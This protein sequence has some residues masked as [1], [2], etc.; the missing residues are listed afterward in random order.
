MKLKRIIKEYF[1]YSASEQNGMIILLVLLFV[2][3][4][5]PRLFESKEADKACFDQEEQIHLDSLV[6]AIENESVSRSRDSLFFFDPNVANKSAFIKLG[7][8]KFQINNILKYRKK[9]G[10]FYR[11][12]D[13]RKIYG[14]R[15]TDYSRVCSYVKIETK[16]S[17][18]NVVA[19]KSKP[20]CKYYSFDPNTISVQTWLSFGVSRKISTRIQKYLKSGGRFRKASDLGKIYG[21]DSLKLKD[22]MPFVS[23]K[24][25]SPVNDKSVNIS[26]LDLNLADTIQLRGMPGIG[27]VLS[28]RIVKYRNLLG[29]FVDKRQLLEV[30]GMSNNEYERI[31]NS[32]SIHTHNISMIDLNSIRLGKLKK[33]PYVSSR[34]ASDIIRY[35]DRNGIFKNKKE[36][37]SKRILSDSVY[38]KIVPYLSLK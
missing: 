38:K 30:Y 8:D 21:M 37:L 29:G 6:Q 4:I 25:E 35:R 20:S 10:W 15:K 2:I 32:I 13:L 27:S 24:V 7:F 26:L 28:A 5:I 22:L 17:K 3:V 16:K 18:Q 11:K 9:G 19:K 33:H 12:S 1:N 36:L 14:I 31:K 23:I 34:L